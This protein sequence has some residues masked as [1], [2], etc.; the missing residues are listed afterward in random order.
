MKKKVYIMPQ[1]EVQEL[2]VTMGLMQ[3][4]SVP[5]P[6]DPSPVR[7]RSPGDFID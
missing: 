1:M 6:P 7:R 3:T 4:T 5:L 2:T